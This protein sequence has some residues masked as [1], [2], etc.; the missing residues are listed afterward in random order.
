MC[1]KLDLNPL[2][3]TVNLVKY[4]EIPVRIEVSSDLTEQEH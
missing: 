3:D 2:F 4:E 1:G